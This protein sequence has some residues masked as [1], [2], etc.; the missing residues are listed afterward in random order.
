MGERKGIEEEG[1]E[2]RE[3]EERSRGREGV[4]KWG[5]RRASHSMTYS[6]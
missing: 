5:A 3:R 4:G 2:G 1:R 6:V